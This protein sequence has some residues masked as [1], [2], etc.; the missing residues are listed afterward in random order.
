MIRRAGALLAMFALVALML[1]LVWRVVRHH[2]D[3]MPDLYSN[4]PA[5][6]LSLPLSSAPTA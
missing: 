1:L 4:E 5:L 2:D 6:V 3:A